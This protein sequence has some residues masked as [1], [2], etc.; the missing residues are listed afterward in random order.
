MIFYNRV[1]PAVR[2]KGQAPFDRLTEYLTLQRGKPKPLLPV[3]DLEIME[4]IAATSGTV[5][6]G[7][8]QTWLTGVKRVMIEQRVD[9]SAF[10]SEWLKAGLKG[11]KKLKGESQP[12]RALPLTL[13]ILAK[14]NRAAL[15]V[16]GR[17]EY[18]ML[19]LSA[20]FALGFGCFLRCGEFTYTDFDPIYHLQ[21]R[22]IDLSGAFPTI[23]IKYSKMDQ[24][25]KGRVLPI[26]RVNNAA[27]KH[28]CPV[29]LL[30]RLL[31]AFPARPEA[32]LFSFSRSK[33]TFPAKTVIREFRALLN[34]T[35]VQ[36]DPD[37]HAW[38]G[39]SFRRGAATWAADIGLTDN[40]IMQLGRWSIASVRGGHQRYIDLTMA[41]R[42]RLAQRLYG[43]AVASS[44]RAGRPLSFLDEEDDDSTDDPFIDD[45]PS[46][47]PSLTMPPSWTHFVPRM[48]SM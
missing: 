15:A 14:L 31:T 26:P 12:R 18:R 17:R 42:A 8:V 9:V 27:Y 46:F 45:S 35:G 6:F 20:A 37:G 7:T 48:Y 10:D 22:D 33:P 41:Q 3:T 21:R 34:L 39:H 36:D 24:T 19:T 43:T 30:S 38:S 1:T 44:N 5:K 23:R 11:L 2:K 25:R 16:R 29:T 32:P 28:V 4:W 13:P 47:G 40:D